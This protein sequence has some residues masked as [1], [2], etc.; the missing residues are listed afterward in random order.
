MLPSFITQLQPAVLNQIYPVRLP[1]LYQN[2]MQGTH[3]GLQTIYTAHQTHH[4]L[5]YERP[6]SQ[7]TPQ[8]DAHNSLNT[9]MLP[10]EDISMFQQHGTP[11]YDTSGLYG[12]H[13]IPCR[14]G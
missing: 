13:T 5:G 10:A 12:T 9:Y 8:Q 2:R 1:A 11:A 4:H 14:L 3:I 7:E 6:H